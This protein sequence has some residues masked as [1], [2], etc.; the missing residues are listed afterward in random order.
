MMKPISTV[1]IKNKGFTLIEILCVIA[2][3]SCGIVLIFRSLFTSLY[4]LEEANDR[5]V[6]SSILQKKII[7]SEML[8]EGGAYPAKDALSGSFALDNRRFYYDV[9]LQKSQ[10]GE[11]FY[12]G[13]AVCHWFRGPKKISISRDFICLIN[14][15][16]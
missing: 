12:K 11:D 2:V 6:A 15:N 10:T 9:L 13:S 16:K 8:I 3:L 4:A 14:E 5:L 1:G 7:E